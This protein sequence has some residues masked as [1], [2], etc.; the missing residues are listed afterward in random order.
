MVLP[1]HIELLNRK[2]SRREAI[3]LQGIPPNLD[4]FEQKMLLL[5]RAERRKHRQFRRIQTILEHRFRKLTTKH[6][7]AMLKEHRGG[8]YDW[9]PSQNE[10][11]NI[12]AAD[13]ANIEDDAVRAVL[14]TRPHVPRKKDRQKIAIRQR[15]QGKSKN[16]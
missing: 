6:L 4:E 10:E 7:L 13:Y 2:N 3:L 14:A 15:G 5:D 16:R 8:D 11:F 9:W 1:P 12:D